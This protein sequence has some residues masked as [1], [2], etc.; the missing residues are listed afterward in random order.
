MLYVYIQIRQLLQQAHSHTG[1]KESNEDHDVPLLSVVLQV[2]NVSPGPARGL[3]PR[4]FFPSATDEEDV[5]TRIVLALEPSG[6]SGGT[7]PGRSL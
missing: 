3:P 6:N 7:F 1:L 5:P 4:T 2:G